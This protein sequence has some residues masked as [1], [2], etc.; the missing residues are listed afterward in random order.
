MIRPGSGAD[1]IFAGI[2]LGQVQGQNRA[3]NETMADM[4]EDQHLTDH[5]P[6]AL[7]HELSQDDWTGK[8]REITG[9]PAMWAACSGTNSP[10]GATTGWLRIDATGSTLTARLVT[11]SGPLTDTFTITR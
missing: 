3:K 2:G 10:G 1:Q 6:V 5:W 7:G 11:T 9:C 8:P 4:S